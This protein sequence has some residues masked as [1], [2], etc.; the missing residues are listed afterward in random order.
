MLEKSGLAIARLHDTWDNWPLEHGT[1]EMW[2]MES[3]ADYVQ[4]TRPEPDV[5]HLDKHWK[6]CHASAQRS[7]GGRHAV[8]NAA[9]VREVKR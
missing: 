5:I 3:L 7:P 2:G 9:G 8:S 4:R 6:I 1:T